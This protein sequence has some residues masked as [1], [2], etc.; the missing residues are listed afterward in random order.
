MTTKIPSCG[1]FQE[2][3]AHL[4]KCPALVQNL[5]YLKWRT[6]KLNEKDVYGSTEKQL[7]IVNIYSDILEVRENLSENEVKWT[8]ET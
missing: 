5:K 6:S 4:L 8:K 2:T 3:Q 7:M 1:L